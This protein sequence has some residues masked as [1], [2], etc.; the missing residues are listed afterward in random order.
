MKSKCALSLGGGAHLSDVFTLLQVGDPG[1]KAT[2]ESVK[3]I[4]DR[5]QF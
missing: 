1:A 4:F 5:F 2:A 3:V